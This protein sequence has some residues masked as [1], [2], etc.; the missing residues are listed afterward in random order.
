MGYCLDCDT[1]LVVGGSFD[2]FAE[3]QADVG[4]ICGLPYVLLM[5]QEPPPVEVL[6]AP[7]L[8]GE[9]YGQ[10]PIYFSDVIVRADS[11]LQTFADLRGQR[12][13]VQ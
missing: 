3:G 4:F 9:R 2:E 7:I 8:E 11:T 1:E 10:R 6:A 5:R 12:L 13:V